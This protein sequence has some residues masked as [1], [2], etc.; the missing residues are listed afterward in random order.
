MAL[1]FP[2]MCLLGLLLFPLYGM[3]LWHEAP[4]GL[5]EPEPVYMDRVWP[6]VGRTLGL[7]VVV[8]GASLALGTLLAWAEVRIRYAG[9]KVWALLSLLPLAV[10]S[11]LLAKILREQMAPEGVLGSLLGQEE[12]F[13]GFW[14]AALCLTLTC[15]PYVHLLVAASLQRCPLGEEE[16]ARSLGASSWRVLWTVLAPRLRPTWGF[17][18]VLVGLYVVSDFGAVAVLDCEVLTW[19]LYQAHSAQEAVL[20]GSSLI[21]LVV[22]L[23]VLVRL[24]HGHT[25][26][27][28]ALSLR[29]PERRRSKLGMGTSVGL[30]HA[31]MIGVGVLIPTC[32]ML[33]W[34]GQGLERGL[35]FADV[36]QPAG[37]SI[38]IAAVGAAL[39]VGGALLLAVAGARLRG[40]PAM[41][42]DNAVYIASA[43]PGILVAV[44]LLQLFLNLRLDAPTVDWASLRDAGVFLFAGLIMRF[45][46]QGYAALKP[47]LLRLDQSQIES[48]RSL[49]AS[50]FM[51]FRT[52]IL[53]HVTP[54]LLAAYVLLFLSI[55][56]ELPI[57]LMLIPPGES[58]LAYAIFDANNEGIEQNIGLAGLTLL[59]IAFTLQL[60]LNRWRRH[61]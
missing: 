9:H 16:A 52:V 25:E 53:P 61:V 58:T 60:G 33:V 22:P 59:A 17:A 8:V 26:D 4:A 45:M 12:A 28:R 20:L 48:A 1:M 44:G 36:L 19:R 46:S 30:A 32:T 55:A 11:Y 42:A 21:G 43:L 24:I 49:G 29:Q 51:R 39:T 56:K 40:M 34:V 2:A 14:P 38:Y 41:L 27:E 13:T 37:T 31:L 6:L 47:T 18:S 23:L 57:T 50:A 10:P 7:S 3:W 35:D 15:T 5:F 54:S